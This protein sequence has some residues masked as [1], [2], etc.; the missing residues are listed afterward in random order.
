MPIDHRLLTGCI[1]I[2]LLAVSIANAGH[3]VP[4]DVQ[5][6]T[7]DGNEGCDV[8]DFD[9]DDKLDVAAGRNWYRNGDWVPRPLRQIADWN[10]YVESNG[11][12]AYDVNA[13]GRPDIVSGSF[14]PSQVFWYENPGEEGLRLGQFW[15]QHLLADTGFS[16]NEAAFLHDINGDGVPEFIFDSWNK[17]HPLLVWSFS[18]EE[19][20]VETK[21]GNKTVTVKQTVP[22]LKRHTIGDSGN[23][24]GMA[25]GDLNNDG[26]EDIL[27]GTGWYER[28]EGDPLTAAWVWHPDWE[29]LHA[30]CPCQIRDLDGDG[31]TDLIWGKG[32]NYGTYVWWGRG[33]DAN[34]KL[35]FESQT[36]DE[37]F[38]QPHAIEFIDLDGDGQD[39]I[40][41]G[42]RYR[43]HNGKDPGGKDK[44]IILYYTFD[45]A[46]KTFGRHVINEGQVGIGLQIRAADLDDDG[47]LELVVAGKD[48][49]QILWNKRK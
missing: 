7:V 32:H 15:N 12:F 42:K 33:P 28:P 9:G 36:I 46:T 27:V 41:T 14:L 19:R 17:T 5:L 6:L 45:P 1:A 22:A 43:A 20:E 31:K 30:A 44:L 38:S 34:G 2:T 48:G 4:F 37:S 16:Q 24:H 47:D 11:E 18:T 26:R 21:Q 39:E 35:Q 10:G 29:D 8:A 49:T 13:D 3:P 23:G 40:V 25:F